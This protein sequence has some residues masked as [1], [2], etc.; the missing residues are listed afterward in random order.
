MLDFWVNQF[1]INFG[2]YCFTGSY[3]LFWWVV[4]Y[5]M[6]RRKLFLKV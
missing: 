4:L 1:G 6:Y 5:W 2:S 3:I